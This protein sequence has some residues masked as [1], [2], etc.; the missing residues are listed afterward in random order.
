MIK[1]YKE[2]Q[3]KELKILNEK[4]QELQKQKEE[5]IT[6]KPFLQRSKEE[7]EEHIV[8]PKPNFLA[9]LFNNKSYTSYQKEVEEHQRLKEEYEKEKE[10]FDKL[11]SEDE[12]QKEIDDIRDKVD[13]LRDEINNKDYTNIIKYYIDNNIQIILTKE[14]KELF[15]EEYDEECDP[16]KDKGRK[17]EKLEDIMLVHK[18]DYIPQ[19]EEIGTRM[20][21]GV[22]GETT[23][24]IEGKKYKVNLRP[25]RNSLHFAANH[26]V[27]GHLG[28]DWSEKKYSII[29]PLKSIPKEKIKNNNAVDTYTKG[30]VK[31]SKD[32]FIICPKEDIEKVKKENPNCI[33]VGYDDSKPINYANTLLWFMGYPV[34]KSNEHG[35]CNIEQS[36]RYASVIKE[37]GYYK[38][39][40][41]HYYSDEK[42]IENKLF[43]V[44]YYIGLLELIMTNEDFRGKDPNIIENKIIN[45]SYIYF[46]EEDFNP[47]YAILIN[48]WLVDLGFEP[49]YPLNGFNDREEAKKFTIELIKKALEFNKQEVKKTR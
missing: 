3:K 24:N 43:D 27:I 15:K 4:I 30:E 2:E 20:T 39:F 6:A 21:S 45:C 44:S 9:K 41:K 40:E 17:I 14:D 36:K 7:Y 31:L 13:E 25:Y 28:G 33:I 46:N 35:F 42:E 22:V 34:E 48:S 8:S 18:T 5:Y 26:E 11:K 16:E 37:S 19:N 1:E 38:S 12:I 32:C 10:E 29:V 47:K 23:T 49:K